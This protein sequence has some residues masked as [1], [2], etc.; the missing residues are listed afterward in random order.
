MTVKKRKSICVC[1]RA[2]VRAITKRTLYFVCRVDNTCVLETTVIRKDTQMNLHTIHT[3]RI[4]IDFTHYNFCTCSALSQYTEIQNWKRCDFRSSRSKNDYRIVCLAMLINKL[5]G[6]QLYFRPPCILWIK[7]G[8]KKEFLQ[9][10]LCPN[11]K[12]VSNFTLFW[13]FL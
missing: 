8:A 9:I 2:C 11:L 7:N 3:S 10:H 13:W 4:F 6:V 12:T 5:K 1:V